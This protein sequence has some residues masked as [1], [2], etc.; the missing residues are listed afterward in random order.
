MLA[1]D[2]YEY[3]VLSH[4]MALGG[5]A[6]VSTITFLILRHL[7]IANQVIGLSLAEWSLAGFSKNAGV[8]FFFRVHSKMQKALLGL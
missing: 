1:A 7:R 8:L 5:T 4:S 2:I 6:P 3:S